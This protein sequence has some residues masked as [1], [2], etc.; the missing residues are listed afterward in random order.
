MVDRSYGEVEVMDLINQ[1]SDHLP[2]E[3]AVSKGVYGMDECHSLSTSDKC[4]VHFMKKRELVR[5]QD[6]ETNKEFSVPVN[7]AIKFGIIYNPNN[8]ANEGRGGYS[9]TL[10]SDILERTPLPKMGLA[11]LKDPDI[12]GMKS[13]EI[14]FIKEVRMMVL[15]S[16]NE[17]LECTNKK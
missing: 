5:I 4:I 7:S 14:L 2:L 8:N 11:S 15:V 13:T 1:Y 10:V 6:P 12:E 9:F 16:S 17:S 3:L